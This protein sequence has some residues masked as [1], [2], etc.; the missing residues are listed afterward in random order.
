MDVDKA[1]T[2]DSS[3]PLS[4]RASQSHLVACRMGLDETCH[5]TL[6]PDTALRSSP[7]GLITAHHSERH[8]ALSSGPIIEKVIVEDLFFGIER[9]L[10]D[11]EIS[12][13][14]RE[15]PAELPARVSV[16]GWF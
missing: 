14:C 13:A 10:G 9:I 8:K 7:A 1:G 2:C 5:E 16:M 6:C 11:P 12:H 4:E 15:S 3:G